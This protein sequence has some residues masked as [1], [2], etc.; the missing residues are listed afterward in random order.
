MGHRCGWLCNYKEPEGL[1]KLEEFQFEVVQPFKK[2]RLK[3]A[4]LAKRQQLLL[5]VQIPYP[6]LPTVWELSHT[7]SALY[8]PFPLDLIHL[9]ESD[10]HWV[11]TLL[12]Y[13]L[14]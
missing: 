12:P 2:S 5:L 13:I 4:E 11:F 1:E 3:M 6:Q 10:N 7:Q 14:S 9:K 8:P